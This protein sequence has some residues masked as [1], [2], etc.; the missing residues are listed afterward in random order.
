MRDSQIVESIRRKFRALRL[1]LDEWSR[2]RWAAAEALELGWGGL[3]AVTEATGLSMTTIRRGIRELRAPSSP[4]PGP[5]TRPRIRQPGGGRQPVAA[6]DPT[7]INDLERLVDP[8]TRGDPQ[9]PLRWTCKSTRN[10]ADQLTRQGHS[11]SPGTVA[12]LLKQLDY[13]LQANRKTREGASHPDRDRQFEYINATVYRFLE[14]G[15]PVVSVDTKKKELLGDFKNGG[16]EYQPRGHPE[17]TRCHDFEDKTLGK[18]IPY[19]VGSCAGTGGGKVG[20]LGCDSLGR[21]SIIPA[22]RPS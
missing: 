5:P 11:V 10:L 17:P 20:R 18:A 21:D 9:S 16:R 14:R 7:L 6:L 3:S 2:R 13:S 1:S 12:S 8:V 4:P 19:G 22:H 15:Q